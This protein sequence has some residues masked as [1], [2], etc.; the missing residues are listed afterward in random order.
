MNE[1]VW[2]YKEPNICGCV[3]LQNPDFSFAGV[4]KM[5]SDHNNVSAEI[6]YNNWYENMFR[7]SHTQNFFSANLKTQLYNEDITTGTLTLKNGITINYSWVGTEPNRV[8]NVTVIGF[9]LPDQQKN[10]IQNLCDSKF[11]AGVVV[12]G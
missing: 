9:N 12:I 4:E 1:T 5:C 11:G 7:R 8:L 2:R 3:F 6:A 10:T